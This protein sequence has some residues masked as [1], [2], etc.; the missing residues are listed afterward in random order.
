[1][2]RRSY[3]VTATGTDI[4]KTYVAAGILRAA[5]AAG[6]QV[7]A[8]KPVLSGYDP[9]AAAGSDPAVLLEAMGRPATPENI[10]AIAPWRFSAPLSPDMAAARENRS[11]DFAA[12][13]A[14]CA[15]AIASAPDVL[16][17]EGVGGAAVPLDERH[18]VADWIAALGIPAILVA[19]TY[20]GTLSHTIATAALLSARGVPI[21]AI[22]LNES[23]DAPVTSEETARVLGRF[24]AYP[25]HVVARGGGGVWAFVAGL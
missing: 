2:T 18:L 20:L 11:L 6:R 17:I 25:V 13:T 14:F 3:F 7:Q 1:M 9:Q 8:L 15:A 4:G 10:A 5:R 22:V 24:L 23:L 12:L 16:L 19:G 21:A